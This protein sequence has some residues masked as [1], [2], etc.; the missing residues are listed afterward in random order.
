[1]PCDIHDD[2]DVQ[3]LDTAAECRAYK[4]LKAKQDRGEDMDPSELQRLKELSDKIQAGI[5]AEQHRLDEIERLRRE[6]EEEAERL[7]R[8]AEEEAERQRLAELER[9]RLE[10]EEEERLRREAEAE[11]ERLR[12]AAE[13]E[14]RLRRLAEEEAERLRLEAL[15]R[16]KMEKKVSYAPLPIEREASLRLPSPMAIVTPASHAKSTMPV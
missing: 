8:E 15:E 10:A 2:I 11:A 16:S 12:L 6:A 9:L 5:D 13:E 1:M 7:R 4:Y 3:Y 14:E